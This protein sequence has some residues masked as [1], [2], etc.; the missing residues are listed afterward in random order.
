MMYSHEFTKEFTGI[1]FKDIEPAWEKLP[2]EP[3]FGKWAQRVYSPLAIFSSDH[4]HKLILDNIVEEDQTETGRNSDPTPM[5][6]MSTCEKA[7]IT[8]YLDDD[9]VPILPLFNLHSHA[10]D[11]QDIFRAF[12]TAHYSMCL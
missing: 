5:P 11:V 10:K 4:S 3:T 7:A 8:I 2:F 6:D 1:S 9:D 12:V